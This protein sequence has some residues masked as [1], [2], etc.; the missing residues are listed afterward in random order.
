MLKENYNIRAFR[1]EDENRP[2]KPY[3]VDVGTLD[4]YYD[5]SMDLIKVNPEFNLYDVN[6]PLRT[7]Q[8]Q[9]LEL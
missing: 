2:D 8:Q 9:F 4:S 1:F 6:W 7:K 5:A 3:W